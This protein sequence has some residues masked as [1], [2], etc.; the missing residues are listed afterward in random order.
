VVE[1]NVEGAIAVV[2]HHSQSNVSGKDILAQLKIGTRVI[3]GPDWKWGDQ[4]H[5]YS[6]WAKSFSDFFRRKKF[7]S[8]AFCNMTTYTCIYMYVY[9]YTA[10]LVSFSAR[11]ALPPARARLS[12]S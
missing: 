3:K 4:V 5:S 2:T 8:I 1:E 12:V 7:S 11:M 6:Y 9:Y 10:L